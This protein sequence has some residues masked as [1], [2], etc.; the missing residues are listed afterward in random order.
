MDVNFCVYLCIAHVY[1]LKKPLKLI[2]NFF[3]FN[4]LCIQFPSNLR[5]TWNIYLGVRRMNIRT[6]MVGIKRW[7]I[8]DYMA[9]LQI[10]CMCQT[11]NRRFCWRWT[12]VTLPLEKVHLVNLF[13]RGEAALAW[14]HRSFRFA[15]VICICG[16]AVQQTCFCF[17]LC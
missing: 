16:P 6:F 3:V 2:Y 14:T 9:Q 11:L 12:V 15:S 4:N 17:I 10:C 7:W 8:Q 1:Y 5:L 13:I